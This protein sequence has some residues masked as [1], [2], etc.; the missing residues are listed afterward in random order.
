MQVGEDARYFKTLSS[1]KHFLAYNLE[2][3]GP[4][5]ETGLCTAAQGSYNGATPYADGGGGVNTTHVCRYGYNS[6]LSDRD[7][8]ECECAQGRTGE[9]LPGMPPLSDAFCRCADYLPAW[10]A[11]ITRAHVQGFMCAY[12]SVNGVPGCAN[13][14]AVTELARGQWGFEGYVVSDCLALQVM[15]Q[16]HHYLPCEECDGVIH[17]P[18]LKPYSPPVVTHQTTSR[19]RPRRPFRQARTTT[20]DVLL[21]VVL[22]RRG[23]TLAY[24][25]PYIRFSQPFQKNGTAEAIARGLLNETAVDA[26]VGRVLHA[27]FALGEF[28]ADVPY[29]AYGVE[30]LDTPAHRAAALE[31]AEQGL[32]LLKND[33]AVLPLAPSARIA[34]IGPAADDAGIMASSYGG[35]NE[36]INSHT[37]WRAAQAAGLNATLTRGCNINDLDGSGIAAAVA[38]AQAADVA[39]LFL[40][41]RGGGYPDEAFESEWGNGPACQNDRPA[42]TLPGM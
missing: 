26:A 22:L 21:C 25:L 8:V 1:P 41:L 14:W 38:A 35:D 34:F 18:W 17:R 10:H 39:V 3:A 32:I 11:I 20:V 28:D 33:G 36:L 23:F 29:R 31:A 7:L 6:A 2:G 40:G 27:L 9:A 5:N 12:P 16:A 30:H 24:F 19:S 37:P 42:L 13:S 4:N 15:M